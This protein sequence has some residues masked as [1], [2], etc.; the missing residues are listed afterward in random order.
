MTIKTRSAGGIVTH[1]NEVLLVCE[2]DCFW[3]FPKGQLEAGETPLQ[4]AVREIAEEA[5]CN[6]CTA[7][8]SL[9]AYER[10]PYTLQNT[11]DTSSIKHITM[12]LFTTQSK[13]LAAPTEPT[14]RA[15][16]VA[17]DEVAAMLTHPQDRD[18]YQG[19]GI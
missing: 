15:R 7:V 13:D 9:G 6:N 19:L 11:L 17:K 18:F 10:H 4:A 12:Y 1:G 8:R 3:G 2:N 16:W 14:I 5:G